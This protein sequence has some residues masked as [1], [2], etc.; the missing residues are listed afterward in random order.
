MILP[1]FATVIVRFYWFSLQVIFRFLHMA[2]IRLVCWPA[3]KH[4]SWQTNKH[5]HETRPQDICTRHAL[6]LS[7]Y[8]H[9]ANSCPLLFFFFISFDELIWTCKLHSVK[10]T[11]CSGITYIYIFR[12]GMY[13]YVVLVISFIFAFQYEIYSL[14]VSTSTYRYMYYE[15]VCYGYRIIF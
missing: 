2:R 1:S 4:S 12:I 11:V 10:V 15:V 13:F 6:A 5:A 14:Y 3:H 8:I 9:T 7:M